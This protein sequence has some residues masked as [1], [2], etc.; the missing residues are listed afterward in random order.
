MMLLS[1]TGTADPE[2]IYRLHKLLPHYPNNMPS[3]ARQLVDLISASLSTL[4]ESCATKGLEIP[5]LHATF[6]PASEAFRADPAAAEAANLIT[7]AALQLAA[8][9]SPP[10]NSLFGIIAAVCPGKIS[11]CLSLVLTVFL[12][13]HGRRCSHLYRSECNRNSSRRRSECTATT[14]INFT[15]ECAH[16]RS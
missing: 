8:I 1:S 4:E 5:D 10:Q 2:N 6:D 14:L 3:P 11:T 9:I 13:F 16:R 15:R 7:A 12:A